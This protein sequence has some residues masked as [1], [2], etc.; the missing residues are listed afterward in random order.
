MYLTRTETLELLERVKRL[1][2]GANVT[3]DVL[4]T[5]CVHLLE[6]HAR[7]N[8]PIVHKAF[9]VRSIGENVL[10]TFFTDIVVVGILVS[11]SS[12]CTNLGARLK[13]LPREHADQAFSIED[14]PLRDHYVCLRGQPI[15][16]HPK[17][18]AG[19]VDGVHVYYPTTSQ[20]IISND[21]EVC[22]AVARMGAT[23]AIACAL[24]L[25]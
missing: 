2:E 7:T 22:K 8:G 11:R 21:L 13:A 16:R 25:D 23:R 10:W 20:F 5:P 12:Q 17:H 19:I 24:T 4:T 18:I 9:N 14:G 1:T 15:S 6:N 3:I